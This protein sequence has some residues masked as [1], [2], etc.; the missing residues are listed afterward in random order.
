MHT[1]MTLLLGLRLYLELLKSRASSDR[2]ENV[3]TNAINS[4]TSSLTISTTATGTPTISFQQGGIELAGIG[5]STFF[6]GDSTSGDHYFFRK[7]LEPQDR[8]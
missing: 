1:V 2:F 5:S 6:I 8:F 7:K 3:Y 4:N